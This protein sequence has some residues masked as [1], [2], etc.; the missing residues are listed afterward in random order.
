MA[1]FT[2]ILLD[3]LEQ[4]MIYGIM[5]LG[6]FISY[7]IL[8]FPDLSVDGTFPLGAAV[9]AF[10]L[11]RGV[12]PWL[13][14]PAAFLLG[15]LAGLMTGLF[16]VLFKINE[17][18]SGI[19]TMTVMYSIN[20]LI[21]GKSNQPFFDLETIFNT[22]PASR[23]PPL[24][25]GLNLRTVIVVFILIAL[26]KFLLDRFLRTKRGLLLRAAG[27]NTR[28]VTAMG[29][30]PGLMKILGLAL[31]NGLVAVSGCVLAQ[32][33]GFFEVTMGT[34]TMVMGLASVIMGMVLFAKV[35]F[36]QPTTK[37]IFGAVI[38]KALVALAINLGAPANML[39]LVRGVLFLIILLAYQFKS[40]EAAED[41]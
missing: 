21:A 2:G 19:L 37:V 16:H 29:I 10:L 33:Q 26:L 32:Q 7:K 23:I 34:G 27:D 11:V 28:V 24:E 1:V 40:K 8:N 35:R 14:L 30:N 17:L 13:A 41:A 39:N 5:A 25:S 4:G 18:F 22:P 31:A 12:N 36:L 9:A 38:Y 6:L 20:L 15:S 3:I